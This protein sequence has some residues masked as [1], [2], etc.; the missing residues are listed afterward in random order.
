MYE[1][2]FLVIGGI[3]LLSPFVFFITDN[4]K[5]TNM[6]YKVGDKVLIKDKWWYIN[7]AQITHRMS[8]YCGTVMTIE[9][10][11]RS[12]YKMKEDDGRFNWEDSYIER[13]VEK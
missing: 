9:K 12:H 4:I 6:K 13:K 7:G 10:V 2:S 8:V 11:K 1:I 3:L 5:R